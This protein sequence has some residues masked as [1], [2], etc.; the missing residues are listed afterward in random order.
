MNDKDNPTV[1]NAWVIC[2]CGEKHR[3]MPAIGAP[4]YWCGDKLLKLE[5]GDDLEIE[6]GD[7]DG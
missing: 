1:T 6:E 2:S 5:A 7:T 3:L 4:V